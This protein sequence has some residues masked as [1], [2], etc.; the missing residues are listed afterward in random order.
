MQGAVGLRIIFFRFSFWKGTPEF[1]DFFFSA[2]FSGSNNFSISKPEKEARSIESFTDKVLRVNLSYPRLA[3][4]VS[5]S[6]RGLK[7]IRSKKWDCGSLLAPDP[8]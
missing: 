8:C 2:L 1:P 7:R 6:Q 4:R 5:L 3:K